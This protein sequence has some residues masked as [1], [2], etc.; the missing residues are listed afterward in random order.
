MLVIYS[1]LAIAVCH[2]SFPGRE[3][4]LLLFFIR[5]CVRACSGQDDVVDGDEDKFDEVADGAHD[6]EAHDAGLKDLHVL[7]VVR[8]LALLVEHDRVSDELL[9]L[10][11]HVL[12]LL[13]SL[14]R[15]LDCSNGFDCVLVVRA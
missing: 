2:E 8:L 3:S 9:H 4:A 15:H 14:L 7:L 6:E 13:L 12:L 11:R 5:A 10:S 1:K